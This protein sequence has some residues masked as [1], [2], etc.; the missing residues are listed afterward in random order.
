MRERKKNFDLCLVVTPKHILAIRVDARNRNT[1]KLNGVATM[2]A[3][4]KVKQGIDETE[5]VKI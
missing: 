2:H 1:G 5:Q 4:E 3:I